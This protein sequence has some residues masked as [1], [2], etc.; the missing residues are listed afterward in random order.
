MAAQRIDDFDPREVFVDAALLGGEPVFPK[1]RL[2]VR[3]VG[4]MLLRGASTRAIRSDYPYLRAQDLELAKL[5]AAAYPRLGR[6]RE[7][8]AA[9]G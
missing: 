6:P 1:T 7:R 8:Q 2:A 5:Y 4:G 3:R 9:A